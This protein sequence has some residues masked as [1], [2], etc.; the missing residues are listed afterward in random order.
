MPIRLKWPAFCT[1]LPNSCPCRTCEALAEKSFPVLP[2]PILANGGLL[3]GYAAVTIARERYGI[4]DQALLGAIAH[5]TTGAEQMSTL[6]KII[7][8]A[9]YIEVN[10]DFDGTSSLGPSQC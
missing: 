10:R 3:H 8:L 2:A 1:M 9:D 5:H 4:T 6:E 7:F